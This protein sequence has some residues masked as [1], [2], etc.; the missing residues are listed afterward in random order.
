M[1]L[2]QS[3]LQVYIWFYSEEILL[4]QIKMVKN[5]V[6]IGVVITEASILMEQ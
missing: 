1:V 5:G 6:K 2:Y 4:C 3:T